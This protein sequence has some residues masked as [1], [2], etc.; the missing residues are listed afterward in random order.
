MGDRDL[1]THVVRAQL[2]AKPATLTQVTQ[3]LCEHLSIRTR[4]LPMSDTPVRTQVLTDRGRLDFQHYFVRD[5]AKPIVQQLEYTGIDKAAPSA[6]A[7]SALQD[8]HLAGIVIA[9]SNPYLSIDPILAVPGMR[10]ALQAAAAPLV[11]VSPIVGGTALKGPAAKIMSEL[12]I[13]PS[14]AAVAR[15]YGELLNGFIAD[16]R[17]RDSVF[18]ANKPDLPLQFHDTIMHTLDDKIR[19]ARTTLNFIQSIGG[20]RTE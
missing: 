14:A 16:E 13:E 18:G 17:D 9:P 2:L 8:P 11:A 12:G 7:L 20:N 15:H 10:T 19:V 4:I 3:T 5:R 6:A 1:A